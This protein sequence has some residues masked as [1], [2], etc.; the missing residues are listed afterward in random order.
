[1]VLV[2]V[3]FVV[4]MLMLTPLEKEGMARESSAGIGSRVEGYT[5]LRGG[6]S[7]TRIGEVLEL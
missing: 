3:V 1:M 7:G 5:P 6:Q 4:V 2:V